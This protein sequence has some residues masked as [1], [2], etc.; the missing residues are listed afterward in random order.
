MRLV[1][2]GAGG[3]GQTVA[4]LAI[5]MKKYDE[6]IF[7]DDGLYEKIKNGGEVCLHGMGTVQGP[8]EDYIKYKGEGTE[9]YPAFGDQK[10]RRDWEDRMLQDGISLALIRH[11]LAYVSPTARIEPGCVLMPY[12]VVNTGSVIKKAC[13]I[14]CNAVVDHGCVLEEGCHI[15]P[16]AIVKA[17]NH[18][19]VGT[20]VDSGEVIAI[21]ACL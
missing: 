20:S 4:D 11:P 2:L 10:R 12:A 18:L 13:I 1:I 5:Q 19:R 9:M 14:N 8:C 7:L 15:E 6:I 21:R 3:H 16:G 17:E